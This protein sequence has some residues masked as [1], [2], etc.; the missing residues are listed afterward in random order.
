MPELDSMLL[1]NP[2]R[3]MA[4]K[5]GLLNANSPV[6]N[7]ARARIA[8]RPDVAQGQEKTSVAPPGKP[9]RRDFL[10]RFSEAHRKDPEFITTDRVLALTVANMFAGSDTTAITLRAL[11]YN[12][13]R[14][15]EDMQSLLQE[16]WL[17]KEKGNFAQEEG[18]VGWNDVREL[19]FL[20][21][22]IKETLRCHPATGL[23]L[24]RIVP[25]GGINIC[26]QFIPAGTVVGC[27]AWTLHQ[28]PLFGEHPEVFYPRRWLDPSPEQ[29]R[30][31]ESAIFSFGAGSRT[32]IGKNIS[33]LEMHKLVP[34]VLMRFEIE[35]ADPSKP[36]TLH[37][38][39]FVKQDNFYVRLRR[40]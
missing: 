39:W 28:D 20:S 9:A 21:A 34:A 36:W 32:C 5:W 26:G 29:K 40:R 10:S 17:E 25:A 8:S 23:P 38:A 37:N 18:L 7:F 11:F 1:K 13:L 4:S 35:L 33:L 30:I 24:E 19:P 16:L 14:H 15:P 3:L 6:V 12:L 2:V 31:M 27:N 22:V